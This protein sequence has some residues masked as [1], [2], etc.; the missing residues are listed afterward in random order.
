P[1]EGQD[2]WD[3][4]SKVKEH[5]AYIHIKD[6]LR[7]KPGEEPVYTFPG[8]GDGCV[9]EIV[10]DLLKSGYQGGMSIEPHLSAIIHLGKEASSEAKAFETYVEYGRRLMRLI[11]Q[12]QN[13]ER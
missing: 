5:I 4:Y 7:P 12:L 11:E 13:A 8:E 2:G 1:A 6:A 10:Q 9:K 3:F